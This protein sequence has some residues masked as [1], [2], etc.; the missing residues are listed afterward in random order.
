MNEYRKC[1]KKMSLA[2]ISIT[3]EFRGVTELLFLS[4]ILNWIHHQEI[5]IQKS[6]RD[7]IACKDEI[8]DRKFDLISSVSSD[9]IAAQS[10]ISYLRNSHYMVPLLVNNPMWELWRARIE[11]LGISVRFWSGTVGPILRLRPKKG[12]TNIQLKA[13]GR[14][15]RT[16]TILWLMNE[17]SCA[18]TE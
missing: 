18:S 4:I 11:S 15:S 16:W 14:P 10:R 2:K 8:Y 12:V 7:N 9:F 3:Q 13:R 1:I 6:E 5:W 17:P